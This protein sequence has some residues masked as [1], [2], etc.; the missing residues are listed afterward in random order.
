MGHRVGEDGHGGL[1]PNGL[2]TQVF[3]ITKATA[4]LVQLSINVMQYLRIV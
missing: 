1:S 4:T 2:Q 3:Q